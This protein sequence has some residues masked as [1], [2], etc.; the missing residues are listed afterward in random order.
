MAE[1]EI[2]RARTLVEHSMPHCLN[3]MPCATKYDTAFCTS[4][5]DMIVIMADL[6]S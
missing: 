2:Q 1:V 6:V 3:P 4:Y 5:M